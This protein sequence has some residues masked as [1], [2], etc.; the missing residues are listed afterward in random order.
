MFRTL[1]PA[2]QH[3]FRFVDPSKSQASASSNKKAPVKK[4]TAVVTPTLIVVEKK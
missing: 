2:I 4:T 1:I 3:V